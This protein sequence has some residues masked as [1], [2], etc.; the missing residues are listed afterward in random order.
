MPAKGPSW[1][2]DTVRECFW[3]WEW[4]HWTLL[5]SK[6]SHGKD[7]TAAAEKRWLRGS[8]SRMDPVLALC[9]LKIMMMNEMMNELWYFYNNPLVL[10]SLLFFSYS[11]SYLQIH[12][13]NSLMIQTPFP[14]KTTWKCPPHRLQ[15]HL[16][17]VSL[18][19]DDAYPSWH[20]PFLHGVFDGSV[21]LFWWLL[22]L[23]VHWC[24]K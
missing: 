17:P 20:K 10:S 12:F 9:F 22:A 19:N 23:L 13:P 14:I 16:K 7:S 11:L 6:L 18:A 1:R 4:A 15:S 2:W 24:W 5:H 8:I 21:F 3:S